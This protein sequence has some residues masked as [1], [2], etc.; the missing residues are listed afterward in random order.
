MTE[1]EWLASDDL[2]AMLEALRLGGNVTWTKAGRRKL[3][4]LACCYARR[5]WGAMEDERSRRA[6]ETAERFVDGAAAKSALIAAYEETVDCGHGMAD[7][8]ARSAVV[9]EALAAAREAAHCFAWSE[10]RA[11]LARRRKQL[12]PVVREVFGYPF[13]SVFIDPAWQTPTV[14][15]LASVAYEERALPSGELEAAR[16]AVLADALEDAGCDNTDLVG[17]LRAPGPHVRGCWAIDLLLG[18]E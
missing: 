5:L 12:G 1:A 15:G 7:L 18:K 3:R 10:G 8:A 6:V 11:G 13:R 16:L 17:H 4:L 2:E 9:A 14:T